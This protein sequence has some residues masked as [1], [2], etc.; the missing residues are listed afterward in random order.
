[1][2]E[3][4]F[5]DLARGLDNGTISRRRALK[6]AGGALLAAV[7]PS[8]FPREAEALNRAKRRCRRKGG[9]YFRKGECHCARTCT[10]Q[11]SLVFNCHGSL[12][13]GCFETVEGTSF[14]GGTT[15]SDFGCSSTSQCSFSGYK[16]VVHGGCSP[17]GQSCNT[18]QDCHNI[19]PYLACINGI[20]QST[21]C[22]SPCPS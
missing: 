7:A 3:Q 18:Q 5:D 12:S 2:N 4:F 22:V 9:I 1:M 13:C 19:Q 10:S 11:A 14:C 17:G 15:S 20:C 21:N 6:L 8:L 16:C